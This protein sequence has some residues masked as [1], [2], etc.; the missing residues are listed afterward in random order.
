MKKN[1]H[2][3]C[4]D[5]K[6]CVCT[7]LLALVLP[8]PSYA[9][10]VCKK[11]ICVQVD[12]VSRNKDRQRGLQGRSGLADSHGMLFV[13]NRDGFY[14]FWMKDMKFPVDMIWIDRQYRIVTIAPSRSPC[15]QDPC[16]VYEPLTPA[17][18]VLELPDRFALKNQ[19]KIGD[20]LEFNGI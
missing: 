5:T 3:L 6:F 1:C 11:D 16:P 12:V 20:V 15:R 8:P 7:I 17:R 18:Y 9:A 19:W 13:F 10:S 2:K 4:R 14:R